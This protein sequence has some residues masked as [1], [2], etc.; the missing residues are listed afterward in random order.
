MGIYLAFIL[1]IFGSNQYITVDIIE[2]NETRYALFNNGYKQYLLWDWSPDYKRYHCQ[3]WALDRDCCIN[4]VDNLYYLTVI[5]HDKIFR[6]KSKIFRKTITNS[7][8]ERQN[9]KLFPEEYRK[10]K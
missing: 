7:D 4:K 9:V 5:R 10:L 3:G 1:S 6:I 2:Y 8:P